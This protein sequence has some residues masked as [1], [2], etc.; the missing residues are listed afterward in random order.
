MEGTF[1]CV[2]VRPSHHPWCE[3]TNQSGLSV[4]R[5]VC[6]PYIAVLF[7]WWKIADDGGCPRDRVA[8]CS[9]PAP[10]PAPPPAT[11]RPQR[12]RLGE[13]PLCLS[14]CLSERGLERDP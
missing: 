13:V 3:P 4:G 1:P 7:F 11:G 12:P 10:D 6:L 8:P 2:C 9:R 14:G 5:Q